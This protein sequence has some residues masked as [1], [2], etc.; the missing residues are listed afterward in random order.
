MGSQPNLASRLEV[1]SIYKYPQKLKAPLS[2]LGRK[3]RHIFTIFFL[4]FRL[5]QSTPHGTYL[6][7]ETSHRPPKSCVNLQ[8]TM[9]PLK[10][11]LLFR[12]L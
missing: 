3:K 2:N 11:E 12:D 8:S 4:F 9:C 10:V 7:K 6:R 5:P 1:G